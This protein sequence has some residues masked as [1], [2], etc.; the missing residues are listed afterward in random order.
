MKRLL[1]YLIVASFLVACGKKVEIIEPPFVFDDNLLQIDSMM[2]H[3]ADSALQ[4]LMSFRA[5]RGISYEFNDNYHSLLLS[6]AFYKTYNPQLNRYC[7]ETCHGASLQ[8]AMRY[9]DSLAFRYPDNDD[10]TMLSARA[11]YMNGVG[12]YENDSIVEACKEYLHTLE[13]MEDH[14]DEKELVGYKAKFMGLTYT[15]LG[16][17]FF[18]NE[19]K[20]AS[21]E[22][23]QTSIKYFEKVD[24]FCL[25]N[26][27]RSLALA[28]ALNDQTDSAVFCYREAIDLAKKHNK[29]S[30][31]GKCLSE[32]APIYYDLG[33]KDS[34]FIMARESMRIPSNAEI[35]LIRYFVYG[36]MLTKECQYD[37]A[38]YYLDKSINSDNLA[39][40]T[41]SAELLMKCHMALGDTVKIQYYKSVYGEK[42]DE[43]RYVMTNE[44]DLSSIYESYKHEKLQKEHIKNIRRRI[45]S[46]IIVSLFLISIVIW[47]LIL[48]RKRIISIKK[49]S[50]DDIERKNK[51]LVE[52]KR[53]IEANPFMSEP[54]C[55]SILETANKQQFKSRVP[56]SAYI[57]YALSKEQL[58]ALKDAMDRHYDNFSQWICKEYPELTND[59]IDY[60]CLYHLGLKDTDIFALMQRAY[61]TIGERSRKLKRIFNSD[62]PLHTII[63]NIITLHYNNRN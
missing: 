2:Q 57:E 28:F 19:V 63:K 53:K 54:I 25:A 11:H 47:T 3:D 33:Y 15:R 4:M 38:I 22:M 17:L 41:V 43:Y 62:E 48:I 36:E 42:L 21:V 51:A 34:A 58:L 39:T 60:L 20:K 13:I 5:E 46:L 24:G 59:D 45:V 1:S 30:V 49:K 12:F 61:P 6:E 8:D 26:P 56:F 10:I 52:M 32:L 23:Y 18:D 16:E 9:F 27:I 31:L 14:F 50:Q 44:N 37:S 35:L 40:K 29:H 55:K 7:S